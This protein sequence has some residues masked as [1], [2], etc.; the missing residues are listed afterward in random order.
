MSAAKFPTTEVFALGRIGP[1]GL[2]CDKTP[3]NNW[4]ASAHLNHE[5]RN[6]LG[7]C[8]KGGRR[9]IDMGALCVRRE[10]SPCSDLFF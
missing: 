6:A 3:E 8:G 7:D 4:R 9:V 1:D 2:G 5:S 10:Y